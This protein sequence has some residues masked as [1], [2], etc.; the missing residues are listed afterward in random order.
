M[1]CVVRAV[2]CLASI[3]VPHCLCIWPARVCV[4]VWRVLSAAHLC[5][6]RPFGM[7]C[8]CVL[9]RYTVGM[10][11]RWMR[12]RKENTLG[13]G[14]FTI[15]K[16]EPACTHTRTHSGER[17][18]KKDALGNLCK[19]WRSRSMMTTPRDASVT[20]TT[21]HNTQTRTHTQN[22]NIFT[23]NLFRLFDEFW[24]L[25]CVRILTVVEPCDAHCFYHINVY[26]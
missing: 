1:S 17:V 13:F 10:K 18:Y 24:R 16:G 11:R 6:C 9:V 22:I 21:L 2:P 5:M 14:R 3:W 8:A 23:D 7:L 4:Y 20:H 12:S 25:F 26:G 15:K 19:L